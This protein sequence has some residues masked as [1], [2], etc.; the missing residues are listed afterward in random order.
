MARDIGALP[1]GIRRTETGKVRSK[2]RMLGPDLAIDTTGC[3]LVR[4]SR[5]RRSPSRV[6]TQARRSLSCHH[7]HFA[8]R[9]LRGRCS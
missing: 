9:N 4:T 7:P 6:R 3:R 5:I 2:D 1:F 8:A